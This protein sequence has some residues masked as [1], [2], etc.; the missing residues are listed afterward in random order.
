M[1]AQ[2]LGR[3]FPLRL[4]RAS[5]FAV[6]FEGGTEA[7]NT[8]RGLLL[9]LTAV[10]DNATFAWMLDLMFAAELSETRIK[11]EA[12]PYRPG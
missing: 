5:A 11:A 9:G 1:V 10:A 2:T 7:A 3:P 6:R 4:E 8:A 12:S